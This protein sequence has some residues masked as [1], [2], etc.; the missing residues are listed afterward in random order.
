MTKETLRV[1]LEK[2]DDALTPLVVFQRLKDRMELLHL[3]EGVCRLM[4]QSREDAWT[5]LMRPVRETVHPDDVVRVERALLNGYHH[6]EQYRQYSYRVMMPGHEAYSWIMAGLVGRRM[7]TG[8]VILYLNLFDVTAE[9][10]ETRSAVRSTAMSIC[11]SRKSFRR[12]RRLCSGKMQIAVFWAR[13]RRSWIIMSFR[14]NRSSLARRMRIW[15]GMRM[16]IP[17]V[18]MNSGY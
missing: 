6:P 1:Q 17:I 10:T 15:A 11:C 7:E 13:I 9:R 8:E 12:R 2:V 16:T 14:R 4:G 5:F 18:M 3:S